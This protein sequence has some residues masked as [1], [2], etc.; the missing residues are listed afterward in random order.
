MSNM[1]PEGLRLLLGKGRRRG[2][3]ADSGSSRRGKGKAGATEIL[4]QVSADPVGP[5]QFSQ[6]SRFMWCVPTT[7]HPDQPAVRAAPGKEHA[8]ECAG[9]PQ[10]RRVLRGAWG[11]AEGGPH[12]RGR[13]IRIAASFHS[14]SDSLSWASSSQQVQ[15]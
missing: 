6:I 4:L 14:V 3:G 8:L 11:R 5:L 15:T 2:W 9:A 7:P 1:L 12:A 13:D 10:L